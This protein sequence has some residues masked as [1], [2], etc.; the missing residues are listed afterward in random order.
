MKKMIIL[1]YFS[2]IYVAITFGQN[3]LSLKQAKEMAMKNNTTI[4]NGILEI[5]EANQIKKNAFTNFFPKISATGFI[6]NA[7]EP[8][9]KYNIPG[10][11]LPVYDGN[12]MN[13]STATQFAYFPGFNLQIFQKAAIGAINITQPIFV[14]GKIVN[15]NRLAK[16]GVEIKENQ[17]RVSQN[18][19]LLKIEQQYWQIVSLQEK[20]K[21]IEKYELFLD[22]IGKQIED[23][24]KSGLIVKNEKLKIQIKQSE[25]KANKLNLNSGK[26]LAIMSLCFTIG[27]PFDSTLVLQED[28]QDIQ[29][30]EN[31]FIENE[32]VLVNRNEY[33]LYEQSIKAQE[34]QAKI[35]AGDYLP[36]ISVGAMGYKYNSLDKD[37]EFITNRFVFATVTIPISDWWGGSYVLKEQKNKIEIAENNF[38]EVKDLLKLQMEK[39]WMDLNNNYRQILIMEQTLC[40]AEENLK[41]SVNGYDNGIVTLSD[42]LEAQALYAE[43][44]DKLIGAKM[45]Y[46]LSVTIYMQAT[47]K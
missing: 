40:Q 43:I 15:G 35:K 36:Q 21:T 16:I 42:L 12:P 41:A 31:Y 29:L 33:Q 38:D 1:I 4:K 7:N 24:Y 45:Q 25:I 39:G 17:Q 3:S 37:A 30:P 47:G 34:L 6:M 11:N 32:S 2:F 5:Q 10:G 26:K 27:I 20:Q 23:A 8:I 44:S 28:L 18:E 22:H 19:V 14:G 9:L 13:L 46:K